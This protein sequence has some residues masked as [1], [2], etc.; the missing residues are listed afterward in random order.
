MT[1]RKNGTD[2]GTL[3]MRMGFLI[4]D[5]AHHGMG[6]FRARFL[7]ER[8]WASKGLAGVSAHPKPQI[9]VPAKSGDP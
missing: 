5:T 7:I 1:V 4:R 8:A 6:L 3:K 9:V 2:T